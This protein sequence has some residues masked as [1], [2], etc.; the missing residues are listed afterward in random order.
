MIFFGRRVDHRQRLR[1]S[2]K[3]KRHRQ[4]IPSARGH[5]SIIADF[6]EPLG[7]DMLQETV[8]EIEYRKRF[9]F[10]LIG[11]AVFESISHFPVVARFD[12]VVCD[13]H[14][15]DIRSQIR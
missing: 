12:T 15:I 14:S 3:I 8:H 1:S 5:E 11:T 4:K 10:P 7:Q 13:R 6:Y 2:Q 9:R